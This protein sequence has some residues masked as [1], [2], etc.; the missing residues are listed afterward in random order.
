MN[1]RRLGIRGPALILLSAIA[2]AAAGCQ[3][4]ASG[5]TGPSAEE[6]AAAPSAPAAAPPAP[7]GAPAVDPSVVGLPVYPG[8][9][10]A[11]Q[12]DGGDMGDGV[13]ALPSIVGHT[14]DEMEKVVAFY[15][16]RLSDWNHEEAHGAQV[17]WKGDPADGF[18]PMSPK[19][20]TRPSVMVMP[21]VREGTPVRVQYIYER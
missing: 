18:D 11:G 5:E 2:M 7:T 8:L 6:A 19:A 13:V 16:E 9:E 17:F 14:T 20:M 21:P 3:E 10:R 4:D 1:D 15:V 12:A